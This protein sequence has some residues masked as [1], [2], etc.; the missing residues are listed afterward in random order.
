MTLY[1]WMQI[2]HKKTGE[3]PN[4]FPGS[5]FIFEEECGFCVF[6]K[7]HSVLII[8]EVVGN[9]I[10]WL[11]FLNAKAK[12]IGCNTLRFGTRRNPKAFSRKY[13]FETKSH[14]GKLHIMEKAV[15]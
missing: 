15:I 7:H 14:I 9:G 13:G 12:E 1:E 4:P 3:Y 8:G 6:I 11:S 2:Y 5:E 10:H